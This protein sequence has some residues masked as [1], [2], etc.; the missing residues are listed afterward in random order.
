MSIIRLNLKVA[1]SRS[2][3][4]ADRG[5]SASIGTLPP[6]A[7]RSVN[8]SSI[9]L[10]YGRASYCSLNRCKSKGRKTSAWTVASL[11]CGAAKMS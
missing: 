2:A 6:T 4:L 5:Q 1:A 3:E 9:L 11:G 10:G 8:P 7:F